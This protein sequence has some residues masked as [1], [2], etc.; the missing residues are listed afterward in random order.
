MRWRERDER[1]GG[2]DEKVTARRTIMGK[3]TP[4]IRWSDAVVLY[5]ATLLAKRAIRVLLTL[6]IIHHNR[7]CLIY[8]LY[9]RTRGG[10]GGGSVQERV[11]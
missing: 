9:L 5:T 10:G 8:V 11:K 1:K 4:C 7:T 2:K 6:I 3:R